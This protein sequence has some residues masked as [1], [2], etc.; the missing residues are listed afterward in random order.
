MFRKNASKERERELGLGKSGRGKGAVGGEKPIAG[1]EEG[2]QI[3]KGRDAGRRR[4]KSSFSEMVSSPL[5]TS[6]KVK[7]TGSDLLW[8]GKKRD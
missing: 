2:A 7:K 1:E 5:P 4:D 8:R 3:L 6:R